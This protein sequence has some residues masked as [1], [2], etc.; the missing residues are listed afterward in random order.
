[1]KSEEALSIILVT[2]IPAVAMII[3]FQ[4]HISFLVFLLGSGMKVVKEIS[5][6]R[7]S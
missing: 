4:K 1:V 7:V 3:C 5:Q 6:F 2:N